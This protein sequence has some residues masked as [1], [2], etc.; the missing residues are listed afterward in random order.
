[1]LWVVPCDWVESVLFVP[2]FGMVVEFP[3]FVVSDGEV[4]G[5]VSGAVPGEVPW[6]EG[7]VSPGLVGVVCEP[8]G[9]VCE[10]EGL[11]GAVEGL[12]CWARTSPGES[13]ASSVSSVASFCLRFMRMSSLRTR[14]GSVGCGNVS[15]RFP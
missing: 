5:V 6:V 2:L 14:A 11:L 7:W 9:A 3:G 13:T 15:R 8:E 4:C 1:M 10:P 12:D